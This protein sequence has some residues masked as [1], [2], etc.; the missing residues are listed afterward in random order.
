MFV[1]LNVTEVTLI[2]M[3]RFQEDTLQKAIQGMETHK[4]K[5]VDLV[6]GSIRDTKRK[7]KL[8]A[9]NTSLFMNNLVIKYVKGQEKITSKEDKNIS[10]KNSAKSVLIPYVGPDKIKF[11][12]KTKW[13]LDKP[14]CV[15]YRLFSIGAASSTTITFGIEVHGAKSNKIYGHLTSNEWWL[16]DD[17]GDQFKLSVDIKEDL[18]GLKL[19]VKDFNDELSTYWGDDG[20]WFK[21][22]MKLGTICDDD[23]DLLG[24]VFIDIIHDN[25]HYP[26]NQRGTEIH[27][28]KRD[29]TF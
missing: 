1:S 13:Q 11:Q 2:V 3:A 27:L 5:D 26:M 16:D 7:L 10:Y 19:G 17:V 28:I 12:F 15:I 24:M 21:K 25:V 20:C 18:I 29:V 9:I 23:E 4:A 14:K 6:S 8:T 22:E